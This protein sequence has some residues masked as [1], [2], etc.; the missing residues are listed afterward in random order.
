MT[1]NEGQNGD[2]P[3]AKEKIKMEIVKRL[4]EAEELQ[5]KSIDLHKQADEA[6]DPKVKEDLEFEAREIDKKAAKL[7]KTAERLQSG[8]LQG[9][10][11]GTGIG[12]GIASGVG[13]AVGALV[14]GVVAI[15]TSALGMLIGAGTGLVHGSWVKYTD[16]FSKDEADSILEESQQEAEK[17][18]NSSRD[19]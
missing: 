13:I 5:G 17:I 14:T 1:E 16:V 6:E 10:A 19:S 11:M 3:S 2:K 9:G 8:W 7:M 4:E 15:P 18:A 12:A